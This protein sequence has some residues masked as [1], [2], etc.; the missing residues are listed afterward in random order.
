VAR[1]RLDADRANKVQKLWEIQKISFHCHSL[2]RL[3]S[4]AGVVLAV[5]GRGMLTGQVVESSRYTFK[6]RFEGS[7]E[8][9]E[10]KKHDLKFYAAADCAVQ[11]LGRLEKDPEVAALKLGAST[12]LED[13]YRPDR[14]LAVDWL[15]AGTPVRLVFRDGDVLAGVP[16]SV[17][18]YEVE[19]D[20]GDG[21]SVTVM[22]HA[23]FRDKP[24]L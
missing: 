15:K 8:I 13:R 14:E 17:T 4:E 19:M 10:I 9:E 5:F 20:C 12:A 23:I 22:T 1:G 18:L 24:T 6:F 11:V 3:G 7:P 21:A 2:R 16:L